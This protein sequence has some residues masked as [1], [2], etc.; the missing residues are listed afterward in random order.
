MRKMKSKDGFTLVELSFSMLFLGVLSLSVAFIIVNTVAA[1]QRGLTLSRINT[2][3]SDLV[4]DMRASVRSSSAGSVLSM[5]DQ[6]T[7]QAKSD[8]ISD[9]ATKYVTYEKKENVKVG[10]AS[11]DTVS[12][13]GAFC[14]GTYSYIWK[15]G[16]YDVPEAEFYS[17]NAGTVEILMDG[18]EKWSVARLTKV[19]D[20]MRAICRSMV[21][22]KYEYVNSDAAVGTFDISGIGAGRLTGE[23]VDL[24][25]ADGG[26]D[27][28]VYDLGV[29]QP[30]ISEGGNNVLYSVSMVLGTT[31]SGMNVT[32]NGGDCVAPKDGSGSYSNYCAINKFNF[33]V[34]VNGG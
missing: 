11:E 5:C 15:S 21:N 14:T 13:Y 19:Q 33:A 10:D 24:L 34:Q 31:A 22:D 17:K 9:N 8:C 28:S 27:L 25:S 30:V 20:T 26:N 7:G 4:D 23:K 32:Q 1:Y 2:V 12:I 6:L 29:S 3:G 18:E 16:Y